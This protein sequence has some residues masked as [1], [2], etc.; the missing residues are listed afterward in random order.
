[1]G[2]S[3]RHKIE[4]QGYTSRGEIYEQGAINDQVLKSLG[5]AIETARPVLN[6]LNPASAVCMSADVS[7]HAIGTGFDV[8]T[9]I[10]FG[11]ATMVTTYVSATDIFCTVKPSTAPLPKSVVVQVVKGVSLASAE[12]KLFNF[13]ASVREADETKGD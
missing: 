8:N 3:Q 11:G 9:K 5:G 2:R 6:S 12:T 7:M 1:M 4:E 13:T 10:I